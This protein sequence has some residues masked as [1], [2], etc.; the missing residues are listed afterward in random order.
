LKFLLCNKI[1]GLF[2]SIE[3]EGR[4]VEVWGEIFKEGRIGEV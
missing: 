2:G 1:K 3:E 4:R